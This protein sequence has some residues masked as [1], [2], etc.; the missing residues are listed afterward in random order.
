[1]MKDCNP[2]SR[3]IYSTD[4]GSTCPDC[5]QPKNSCV[6]RQIKRRAVPVNGGSARIRYETAGR[7][8]KG[9]TLISGLSL[10]QEALLVLSRELKQ[11]FGTGGAVKDYVIELQGDQREKVIQVLRKSGLLK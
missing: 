6:C 1:M 5:R 9:M 8:G 10:S 3:L 11:Q 7:K 4:L 2:G